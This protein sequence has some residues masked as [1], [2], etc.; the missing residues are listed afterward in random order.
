[1]E[2]TS[3]VVRLM[4]LALKFALKLH[5]IHRQFVS[6]EVAA[7]VLENKA[8]PNFH[9]FERVRCCDSTTSGYAASKKGTGK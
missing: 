9:S 6:L 7:K 8:S 4:T 3:V 5:A 1:M 2:G